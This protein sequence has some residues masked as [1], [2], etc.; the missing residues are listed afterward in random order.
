MILKWLARNNLIFPV[1][2]KLFRVLLWVKSGFGRPSVSVR[3]LVLDEKDQVFLVRH[4]YLK[5]WYFP[6]GAIDKGEPP[7]AAARRELRE[8]AHIV[9]DQGPSL[10]GLYLNTKSGFRDYIAFY[11]VRDWHFADGKGLA[12]RSDDGEIAERGFFPSSNLPQ[13]TT[14]A[15]RRQIEDYF[16][17]RE[18]D[19]FW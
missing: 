6:G 17:R 7:I 11:L 2:V 13:E 9:C 4:T 1:P 5:G 8:E 3:L 10:R 19:G 15:T 14:K 12:A 16:A 18:G